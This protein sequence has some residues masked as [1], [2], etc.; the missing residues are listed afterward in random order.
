MKGV[1]PRRVNVT[2]AEAVLL[3]MGYKV[4]RETFDLVAVRHLENG[5]R[6]HTRIEAHGAPAIPRGAEIDVH[7]DYLH[8]RGH[9]HGS[10]AEGE[11]IAI[12]MEG[13]VDFLAAAKPSRGVA[14]F[15]SCPTCGKELTTALFPTHRK[16]THPR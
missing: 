2:T 3:A 1:V 10:K 15:L 11:T 12:E 4:Y 6:F 14:G 5:K 8:E 7:I 9:N 16:V 13:L